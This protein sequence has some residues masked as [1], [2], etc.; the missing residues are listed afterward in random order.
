[1]ITLVTG[2]S[3]CGKS[4]YAEKL[5]SLF[6]GEKYYIATMSPVGS[7]AQE[8]IARH[9]KMREGKGYITIEQQR[10]IERVNVPKKS[11]VLIECLGNICENEMFVDGEIFEPADKIVNGI[12]S[13]SERVA[14]VI[15]VTNEIGCDGVDYSPETM[16]YISQLAE[17]NRRIAEFSDNVIECVYGIPLLRKGALFC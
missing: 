10:S 12:K 15:I 16:L 17:I 4:R 9:R 7:D 2:G 11:G 14:E 13:L 6:S 3:K 1:M 8:I 5:F